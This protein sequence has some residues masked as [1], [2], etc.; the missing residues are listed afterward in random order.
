MG[1]HIGLYSVNS[2]NLCIRIQKLCGLPF[3]WNNTMSESVKADMNS[4][5][6]ACS[7]ELW[8]AFILR[9]S[10]YDM[11]DKLGIDQFI[12]IQ[13]GEVSFAKMS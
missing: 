9:T 12:I 11:T 8:L 10:T 6:P 4:T 3:N 1:L 5:Y 7:L 13:L 2:F